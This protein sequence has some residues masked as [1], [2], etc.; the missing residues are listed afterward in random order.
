MPIFP[1][2]FLLEFKYFNS[3]SLSCELF[4]FHMKFHFAQTTNVKKTVDILYTMYKKE[5][6]NGKTFKCLCHLN[7]LVF[8]LKA[9]RNSFVCSRV[10]LN[11]ESI[12][13]ILTFTFAS[14]KGICRQTLAW[15]SSFLLF[16]QSKFIAKT[17]EALA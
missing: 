6:S 13:R 7:V 12:A 17:K 4:P 5:I 3:I 2:F 1:L 11:Y 10:Y 9:D 14:I 8:G 16:F 15:L